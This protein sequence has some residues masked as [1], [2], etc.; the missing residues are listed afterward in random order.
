M[1]KFEFLVTKYLSAGEIWK[2][3]III[4][5]DGKLN[6]FAKV[7]QIFPEDEYNCEFIGTC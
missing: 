2:H 7:R 4:R 1:S 6:A 3:H 5:A